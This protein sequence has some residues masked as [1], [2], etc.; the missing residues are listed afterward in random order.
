[1]SSNT[2]KWPKPDF[3]IARFL[4]N[5]Q[6]MVCFWHHCKLKT[7]KGQGITLEQQTYFYIKIIS[8]FYP[9]FNGICRVLVLLHQHCTGFINTFGKVFILISN[10][11]IYLV[12]ILILNYYKQLVFLSE[13]ECLQSNWEFKF[14]KLHPSQLF[15]DFN[16]QLFTVEVSLQFLCHSTVILIFQIYFIFSPFSQ[17]WWSIRTPCPSVHC[18]GPVPQSHH[19]LS[20]SPCFI[21]AHQNH[22]LIF[23]CGAIFQLY[24]FVSF[25]SC[26]ILGFWLLVTILIDI[27]D[28][29]N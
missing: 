25:Q 3:V 24:Y 15:F 6:K 20:A 5:F 16:F 12:R 26:L 4:S 9:V 7:P 18:L 27:I 10:S 29:I 23:Y 21:P 1:M 8:G 28:N 11:W 13:V 22:Q 17:C 19:Q 2:I 14:M